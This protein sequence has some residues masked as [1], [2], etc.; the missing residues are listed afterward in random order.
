[1]NEEV[2]YTEQDREEDAMIALLT[3]GRKAYEALVDAVTNENLKITCVSSSMSERQMYAGIVD[4]VEPSNFRVVDGGSRIAFDFPEQV[5]RL[6]FRGIGV[7]LV[8]RDKGDYSKRCCFGLCD[9][10][11][12]TF[13]NTADIRI[14]LWQNGDVFQPRPEHLLLHIRHKRI[15]RKT[16]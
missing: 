16:D 1:M 15:K 8:Q 12:I 9:V 7:D 5:E 11:R 3:V 6:D 13:S 4:V 10:T 2:E 14:E